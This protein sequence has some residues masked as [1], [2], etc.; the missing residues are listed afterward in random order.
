MSHWDDARW[1]TPVRPPAEAGPPAPP[2]RDAPRR[3]NV[4]YAL[5]Q[6][7][8]D[9]GAE[10]EHHPRREVPRLEHDLALPD[11]L[12]VMTRDLVAADPPDDVLDHATHLVT[13][14]ASLL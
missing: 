2:E 8:A 12:R 3:A 9:A 1:A 11:Q 5:V 10:A 6:Q 4:M 7:L 14:T 13:Q